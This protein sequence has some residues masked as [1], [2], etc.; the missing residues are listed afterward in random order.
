MDYTIT[1]INLCE[2]LPIVGDFIRASYAP[3]AAQ[4]KITRENCATHPAYQ[5]DDQLLNR[6]DL[7]GAIHLA[8]HNCDGKLIGFCAAVPTKQ[9]V[10]E[11]LRLCVTSENR[12]FGVG[13]ALMDELLRKLRQGNA[14]KLEVGLIDT[15]EPLK[16][17]YLRR[18]FTQTAKREYS[19]LPFVVCHMQMKL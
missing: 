2:N 13:N 11:G 12:G 15:N 17:W 8:A 9:Q 3:V 16:T 7:S 5:P 18:G 6:L 10:Y 4:F 1:H 19:G 14:R